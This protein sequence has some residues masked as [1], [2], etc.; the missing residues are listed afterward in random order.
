MMGAGVVAGTPLDRV[1][2]MERIR[3]WVIGNVHRPDLI[4]CPLIIVSGLFV[5]LLISSPFIVER[6]SIDLGSEGSVGEVDHDEAISDIDNPL[7]RFSYRFGD[8]YCH[9]KDHR[10]YFLNG[11]QMPVCSRDIGLFFGIL[12]GCVAGSMY[13]KGIKLRTLAILLAP[14]V[15][16]GLLQ[17]LTPY[18]SFN[19]LRLITGSIG[20][21]GI[22]AYLNGS[23]VETVRLLLYR[24][25]KG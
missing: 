12:F 3:K 9:Q 18:E 21:V 10:S 17:A 25:G 8:L 24:T 13:R 22:G 4:G 15:I 6:G 5:I 7:A 11:N 16:D 19:I 2:R 1:A 20:G 23:L 14:M